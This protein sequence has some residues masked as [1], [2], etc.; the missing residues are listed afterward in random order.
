MD[1]LIADLL[2]L[3]V[4]ID[5]VT[6]ERI[7]A[8]RNPLATAFLTSVTSVGSVAM[9]FVIVSLCYLGG[10]EEESLHALVA[11]AVS[12]IVVAS[13]MMLVQRP[14]PTTSVCSTGGT[15]TLTSSFPS[16]H[17]AAVTVYAMTARH[18]ERLP[19]GII[20]ALAGVVSFS[21]IYLGTHYLIDT[22]VGIAIGVAAFE[23]AVVLLCR[24]E[25]IALKQRIGGVVER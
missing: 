24:V 11:L 12:G 17:A 18:S 3:L 22:I 10:W 7:I 6:M 21:R 9:A 16:G 1:I 14:F 8:L 20:A 4:R 19:F 25:V 2:D 13:L 23:L 5:H 15:E